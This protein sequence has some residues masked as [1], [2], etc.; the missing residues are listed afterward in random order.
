[1]DEDENESL[2]FLDESGSEAEMKLLEN[3]ES[4]ALREAKQE[5]EEVDDWKSDASADRVV[6]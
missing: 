3:D 2:R 1:V 6:V 5:D 4:K